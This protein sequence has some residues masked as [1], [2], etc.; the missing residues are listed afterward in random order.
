MYLIHIWVLGKLASNGT[1]ASDNVENTRWQTSLS[2]DFSKEKR[3]EAR[4]SG[5]LHHNGVSC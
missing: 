2:A 4:V 1:R 5:G 3:G